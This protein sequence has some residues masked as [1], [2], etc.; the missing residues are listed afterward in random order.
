M[1]ISD[2]NNLIVKKYMRNA[3]SHANNKGIIDSNFANEA[4]IYYDVAYNSLQ[5]KISDKTIP[6]FVLMGKR[7]ELNDFFDKITENSMSNQE[8]YERIVNDLSNDNYDSYEMFLHQVELFIEQAK[9][10][11]IEYS[12]VLKAPI[13]NA[14]NFVDFIRKIMKGTFEYEEGKGIKRKV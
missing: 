3:R 12:E 11:K 2:V 14:S 1:D 4:I 8:L 7:K 5:N 13:G 9:K 6:S 10:D